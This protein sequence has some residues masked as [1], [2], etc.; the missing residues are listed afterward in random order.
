MKKF[1]PD[2]S[3]SSNSGRR[4]VVG[5]EG[6]VHLDLGGVEVS[7]VLVSLLV[8]VVSGFDDGI[9]EIGKNFVGFFITSDGTDSHDEG[10]AGIVDTG[11]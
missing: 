10:V 3:S 1:L 9:E 7:L 4:N 11:L 6:G 5:V 8:T 2:R